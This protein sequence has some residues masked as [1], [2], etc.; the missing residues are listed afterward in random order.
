MEL[1]VHYVT[2]WPG[3]QSGAKGS[4]IAKLHFY[5]LINS[6]LLPSALSPAFLLLI[7]FITEEV[8]NIYCLYVS[9][10]FS[11]FFLKK[12]SA[13]LYVVIRYK[14]LLVVCAQRTTGSCCTHLLSL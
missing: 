10:D 7:C 2:E 11:I 14:C 6:C 1:A 9:R 13:G 12:E 8:L 3:I 5:F 4:Q